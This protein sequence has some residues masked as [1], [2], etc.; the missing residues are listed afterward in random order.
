MGGV[1]A[2]HS[3]QCK[4]GGWGKIVG[5]EKYEDRQARGGEFD[6]NEKGLLRFVMKGRRSAC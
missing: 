1:V 2:V 6:S 5:V 4:E 3:C